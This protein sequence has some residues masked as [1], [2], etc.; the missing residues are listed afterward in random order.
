MPKRRD[1]RATKSFD[2]PQTFSVKR[3]QAAR[4]HFHI[5]EFRLYDCFC[6]GLS[7]L[8]Q[9]AVPQGQSDRRRDTRSDA[10]Q[11]APTTKIC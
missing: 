2:A 7:A 1:R 5:V 4:R 10:S 6:N 9:V 8:R 3:P 11:S